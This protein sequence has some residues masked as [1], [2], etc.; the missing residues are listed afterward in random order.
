M[1]PSSI[2]RKLPHQ[3]RKR[4][5]RTAFSG[6]D[7]STHR[8]ITFFDPP[9]DGTLRGIVGAIEGFPFGS[10]PFAIARQARPQVEADP[11]TRAA[12][13]RPNSDALLL[14]VVLLADSAGA[15]FLV[16]WPDR[17]VDS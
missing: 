6:T 2:L 14:A 13:D 15:S 10:F 9:A 8:A 16:Q 1:A 12:G 4:L 7:V 3:A 11:E 17:V 5:T